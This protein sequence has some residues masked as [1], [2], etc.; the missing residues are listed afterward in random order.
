M[1]RGCLIP[2]YMLCGVLKYGDCA[3]LYCDHHSKDVCD[4]CLITPLSVV[5]IC[6]W[7]SCNRYVIGDNP[8]FLFWFVTFRDQPDI[9]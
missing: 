7:P 8:V 6:T 2:S 3:R 1:V 9:L 5:G 4:A